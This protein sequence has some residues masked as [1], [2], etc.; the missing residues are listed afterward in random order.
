MTNEL[1]WVI[2]RGDVRVLQWR[3][4]DREWHDVREIDHQEAAQEDQI[5]REDRDDARRIAGKDTT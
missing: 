4:S 2:Y 3:D 5:A 1:R